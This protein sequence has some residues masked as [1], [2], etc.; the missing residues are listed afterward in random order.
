MIL[1][2]LVIKYEIIKKEFF[3]LNWKDFGFN[4]NLYF[5]QLTKKE[6]KLFA[7]KMSIK[8]SGE[9][10]F[11]IEEN[12]LFNPLFTRN[13]GDKMISSDSKSG[14]FIKG[15]KIMILP[16]DINEFFQKAMRSGANLSGE[17]LIKASVDIDLRPYFEKN[18]VYEFKEY[19]KILKECGINGIRKTRLNNLIIKNSGGKKAIF[20]SKENSD[21]NKELF[22]G[23]LGV[24]YWQNGDNY[25]YCVGVGLGNV[26]QINGY[27]IEKSPNIKR[28]EPVKTTNDM[29]GEI[30][31]LLGV[32]LVRLNAISVYPFAFKYLREFL[33]MEGYEV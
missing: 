29:L 30:I 14:S 22:G 10:D 9:F 2:N 11:V 19:N 6:N 8:L 27:K 32:A 23:L 28:I 16:N 5:S 7:S 33:K 12:N 13:F 20:Q 1:I 26:G 21:E 4:E 17:E 31:A 24:H 18:R 15:T 3:L 25:E